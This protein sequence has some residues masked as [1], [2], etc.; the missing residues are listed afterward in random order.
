MKKAILL[1]EDEDDDVLF[2]KMA[3]EK[4]GITHP[5]QVARDGKQAIAYLRGDGLFANRQ[6]YPVPQ[7]MLLDL[8]LPQ[9]PGL[10][11]LKWTR[12]QPEFEMLPVVVF[13]SS[14]QDADVERA[15]RLG[16]NSY[17]VKPPSP[18]ELLE[19]VQAIKVYWLQI[20]HAPPVWVE[21]EATRG[22]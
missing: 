3:M 22:E 15:Y 13:T 5:L 20:N 11:V 12:E 8:R 4:A 9:I 1:V 14:S 2:M 21:A 19:I 10:E 17:I 7:L 18:D 6:Q 16:A